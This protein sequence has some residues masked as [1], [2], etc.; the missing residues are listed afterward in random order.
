MIKRKE[1]SDF[2]A[3]IEGMKNMKYGSY[4]AI[5]EKLGI[6]TRTLLRYRKG[7]TKPQKHVKK[8]AKKSFESL[9]NIYFWSL[10]VIIE[11]SSGFSGH[12]YTAPYQAHIPS[13]LLDIIGDLQEKEILHTYSLH[14]PNKNPFDRIEFETYLGI[15]ED[16]YSEF[17]NPDGF[18]YDMVG[19]F[20]YSER[21]EMLNLGIERLTEMES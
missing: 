2:N 12:C 16:N 19:L 1:S 5:A 21:D 9:R 17:L 15:I 7:E 14:D 3:F 11:E 4:K 20:P 10:V 13:A 18:I 6:S 8:T